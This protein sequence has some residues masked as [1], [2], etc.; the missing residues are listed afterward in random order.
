VTGAGRGIGRAIAIELARAGYR[1]ASPRAAATSSKK[2]APQPA[3][4][5]SALIVLLDL[6]SEEAPTR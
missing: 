6:A 1:Y 5:R 4:A 2:R 3:C